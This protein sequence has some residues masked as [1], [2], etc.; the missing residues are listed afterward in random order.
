[1]QCPDCNEIYIQ[2]TLED[3]FIKDLSNISNI[4]HHNGNSKFAKHLLDNG[5]YVGLIQVTMNITHIINRGSHMNTMKRLYIYKAF[6]NK[7]KRLC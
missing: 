4:E 7:N 3:L 1:M 5:H 2:D 6:E